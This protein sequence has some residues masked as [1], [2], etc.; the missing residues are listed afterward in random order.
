[1]DQPETNQETEDQRQIR[2]FAEQL[3][4]IGRLAGE[5]I[6]CLGACMA[7]TRTNPKVAATQLLNIQKGFERV[8]SD[9]L[10]VAV[11][12]AQWE[13]NAGIVLVDADGNIK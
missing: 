12:L 9:V 13:P 11:D 5:A 8:A 10:D 1:M 6:L 2:L 4:T 3:T 7:Q